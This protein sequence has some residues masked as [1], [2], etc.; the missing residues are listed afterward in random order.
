ML[1]NTQMHLLKSQSPRKTIQAHLANGRLGVQGSDSGL[2]AS[3]SFLPGINDL[4]PNDHFRMA[5][6]PSWDALDVR[7][8]S[9]SLEAAFGRGVQCGALSDYQQTLDTSTATLT[10]A[11]SLEVGG[12]SL[13]VEVELWLPHGE[14]LACRRVRLRAQTPVALAI[15]TGIAQN[16][17]PRRYPFRSIVWPHPDYPREYGQGFDDERMKYI[18]H[19][20]HMDV[21]HVHAGADGTLAVAARAAGCGPAVGVGLALHTEGAGGKRWQSAV[22]VA[23]ARATLDTRLEADT[24]LVIESFA[25]FARDDTPKKLLQDVCAE[26]QRARAK[27]YDA[28]R[29]QHEAAW[30]EVWRGGI[31][32][33]G[34]ER[35]QRQAH[36]DLFQLYQNAPRDRRYGF[37]ICGMAS[38]G[39][40][41]GVFWDCDLYANLAL[42]P[43][44][45]ELAKN[46]PRFRRRVLNKARQN[47]MG[48]GCKGARWSLISELFEGEENCC[49][50]RALATGEIHFTAAAAL[51][52][53]RV[54]CGT[55]DREFLRLDAWP[56]I[57]AAA[58][59]F[60]SRATWM[61]WEGRYELL[62]VH[63]AE[64]AAGTVD[65]CF[66]TN[67]A[68]R[69]T[70][71]I[72]GRA[73]QLTGIAPNPQWQAVADNL[74]MPLNEATG[75]YQANSATAEPLGNRWLEMCALAF[76]DFPLTQR[77]LEDACGVPPIHWD[78]SL[79]ALVAARAG[80][81]AK[82]REYLDHQITAFVH[83]DEFLLRTEMKTNDAG[84]YL[85]GSG[86]LIQNLL[87][88]CGGLAWTEQ[89]LAARHAPCL[90]DGVTSI[91]FPRLEWHEQEYCVT[92]NAQRGTLIEPL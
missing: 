46:T 22:N 62:H 24:E 75:L 51:G 59:Y 84:P 85:A 40:F 9:E 26:A 55:G 11:Y 1:H 3:R 37:Q 68:A 54:F 91:T 48:E 73:A 17:A 90:P 92:V 6:L 38:P 42:L 67:A 74:W 7:V 57:E 36:A 81:A 80:N 5:Q 19:P 58:E 8:Q 23:D 16:P 29:A 88:G 2:A 25:A 64:E 21:E 69:R 31:V 41:G 45:P 15:T 82:M 47:A 18:W 32:I 61:S 56:V 79:Q 27:G 65:N 13:R 30:R 63:S 12:A 87:L 34:D 77:Q 49:G 78:M 71:Q 66:Y 39:Y 76:A 86:C 4:T 10:T 14:M 72:A 70:L 44:A 28:I 50:S 43:F 35:L 52:A 20:G 89:G 83:D 53:W 33:E 60:A